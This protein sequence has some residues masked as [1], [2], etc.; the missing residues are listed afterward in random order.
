MALISVG[1][2]A[3]TGISDAGTDIGGRGCGDRNR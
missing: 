2:A 3:V 1:G